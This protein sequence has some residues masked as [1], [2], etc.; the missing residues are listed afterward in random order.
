MNRTIIRNAVAGTTLVASA[1]LAAPAFACL[2]SDTGSTT[3]SPSSASAAWAASDA[4]SGA[5]DPKTKAPTAKDP[6]ASTLT[7]AEK[8]AKVLDRIDARLA[9]LKALRAKVVGSD[10]LTSEQQSAW[11]AKID[12]ATAAL[13]GLRSDVAADTTT[14]QLK[15]DLKAF[16]TAHQGD[17]RQLGAGHHRWGKHH[18]RKAVDPGRDA[19]QAG[20]HVARHRGDNRRDGSHESRQDGQS[21]A[22][23]TV[24]YRQH[25]GAGSRHG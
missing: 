22:A 19:K 3:A 5:K 16:A 25:A 6:K 23:R 10:R 11:L 2:P 21:G 18:E 13:S 17:L 15:D 8:R 1:A 24:S 4:K 9:G 14:A 12:A 7:F 20:S